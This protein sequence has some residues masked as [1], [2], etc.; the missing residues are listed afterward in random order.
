MHNMYTPDQVVISVAGNV[1]DSFIKEIEITILVH[2]R[3]EILIEI[4]IFLPF[5]QIRPLEKR[6]RN[7]H[8]YASGLRGLPI[9]HEDIY[10]L[11]V[12]KYIL[13]GSMVF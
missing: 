2:M 4:S 11:I 3:E 10:D 1:S 9:G 7:K 8:T 13:G 6:I 12:L 5:I